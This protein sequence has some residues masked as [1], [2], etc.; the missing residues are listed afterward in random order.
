V[1]L[2]VFDAISYLEPEDIVRA[3]QRRLVRAENPLIGMRI[4]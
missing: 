1:W 4:N 2:E 3:K